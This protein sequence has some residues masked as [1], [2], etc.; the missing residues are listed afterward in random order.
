MIMNGFEIKILDF[1]QNNLRTPFFDFFFSCIT[2]LGD[3]GIFWIALSIILLIPK[4]TR[5]VGLTMSLSIIIGYLIGNIALKNIVARTRP[6]DLNTAIKLIASKPSDYSFP[7]GH[8]LIS[9]ECAVSIFFYNKKW[10]TAALVTAALVGL[11][12]LYLYMHYPTDVLCGALLG[13]ATAFIAKVI[14]DKIYK[15]KSLKKS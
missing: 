15:N 2:K 6:Y 11:S 10:G 12:R 1:I 5:K 4:K 9:V 14:T 3:H 7:S 13:V 8:T